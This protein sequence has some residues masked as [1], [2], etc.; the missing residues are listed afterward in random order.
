MV[1][2]NILN[3]GATPSYNKLS[4][5]PIHNYN[6]S[7][8]N[9]SQAG[10]YRHTGTTGETF[11]NGIVYYFDGTDYLSQYDFSTAEQVSLIELSD[12][13]AYTIPAA[14]M[15]AGVTSITGRDNQPH[16]GN[17]TLSQLG[18]NNVQDKATQ[19]IDLN[20][21]SDVLEPTNN[22]E[23][24]YGELTSLEL[25]SDST[26]NAGDK[27][28][29]AFTSGSMATTLTITGNNYVVEDSTINA[30][31]YVEIDGFACINDTSAW[32]YSL[33]ISQIGVTTNA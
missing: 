16:T 9:P 32:K 21:S 3:P 7:L 29:I 13:P 15:M 1:K 30:S 10:Y 26:L 27:F 31:S 8:G 12:E 20:S 6:L 19:E 11:V 14:I 2:L 25:T 23:Y 22:T 18:L 24:Y 5:A 17:V 33:K 28:H 4:D